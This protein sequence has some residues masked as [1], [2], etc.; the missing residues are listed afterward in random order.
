MSGPSPRINRVPR[1]SIGMP[2]YNGERY[3]GA[4]IESLVTQTFGDFELIISDNASTDGTAQICQQFARQDSRIRYVRHL[5]TREA[6]DNFQYVLDQAR[7]PY[8]MWAAHD[9]LREPEFLGT[10]VAALDA[11]DDAVLASCRYDLIG[12]DGA[13]LRVVSVD[14][15][16]ILARP[17]FWRVAA[18]IS[19]DEQKTHKAVHIYG[20]MRRDELTVAVRAMQPV[21]T[22]SGFDVC[23]LIYLMC[24]GGV[25]F[26]DRLLM[27]YRVVSQTT[28]PASAAAGIGHSPG[29]PFWRA[30]L[31]TVLAQRQRYLD[32]YFRRNAEYFDGIRLALRSSRGIRPPKLLVLNALT[33]VRQLVRASRTV[34]AVMK[35]N[36]RLLFQETA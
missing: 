17:P 10:L 28:V 15:G 33:H 6:R 18:M 14:W 31:M 34:G 24:R 9:D 25:V 23:I 13:R 32:G 36:A 11:T 20:L 2:V 8:F 7:A 35:R 4:A 30:R 29:L 5:R 1:V 16:R 27:H 21:D 3:L 12:E 26:V 19:L 22:Y